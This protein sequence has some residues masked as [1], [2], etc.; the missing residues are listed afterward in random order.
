MT[1]SESLLVDAQG[2]SRWYG[3][4]EAVSAVD[5]RLARGE[6]LGFLG[7]NGAGKTTTMRMLAGTLA[8]HRGAIRIAGR[9]LLEEPRA[10]KRLIGYLPEHPPLHPELTV[11]ESLRFA[12]RLHGVRRRALRTAVDAAV[13]RTGLGDVRRRLVAHLSKGYQQRLGLA[14]AVL[15]QPEVLILDEP[16]VGLDPAQIQSI[17]ALIAELG[18]E[19][20]VLLSS[21]LLH[22][23]ESV[24]TRVTIIHEG[25]IVLSET[26]GEIGEG[27]GEE[28]SLLELERPPPSL[29]PLRALPGV[30]GVEAKDTRRYLLR[31][32][33]GAAVR[34]TLLA[35]AA[36]EGWRPAALAPQRRDL[37]DVFL[38][39]TLGRTALAG[40]AS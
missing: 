12:G 26:L 11:E 29:E 13:E 19:H 20:G 28:R 39:L 1:T 24:C 27:E 6:I 7:L 21:H 4:R 32:E 30:R 15:H 16:T 3:A 33:A 35:K 37:E 38:A 10:A 34:A 8:P 23:V 18:R 2:L 31:H 9:D 36:Q 22:E 14:Q 40:A 17:R 25:R 5:L